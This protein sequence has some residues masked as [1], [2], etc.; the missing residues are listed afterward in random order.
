[1]QYKVPQNIDLEDKIVGPFTMKQFLYLMVG[2]FIIYG[3]WTYA[4]QFES[5]SPM[6]IFLALA[7]PVGL[8]TLSLALVK[9]NDRPFEF[10]L[11]NLFRF[12]F[13]P[14]KRMWQEG[15]TPEN[16]IVLDK[17]DEIKG[18]ERVVHSSASLDDLAKK[19][20]VQSKTILQKQPIKAPV[21]KSLAK[22]AQTGTGLNLSVRD[23]QDATEQQKQAQN[24]TAVPAVT[25][26]A[27]EKPKGRGIMGFF[28]K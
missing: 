6:V 8:I 21:R 18:G 20:D 3:W 24:I 25:P 15:Y 26:V 5:P 27:G 7:I 11:L 13:T 23:V 2:G 19:L 22:A 28:K 14:K 4:Q 9:M 12:V 1:M 17:D 10:F 16:V